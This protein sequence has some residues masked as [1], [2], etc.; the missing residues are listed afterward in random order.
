MPVSQ[1]T[2]AAPWL[3]PTES[4]ALTRFADQVRARYRDRV[5]RAVLFG[6]RARGEGHE[7]SDL[8]VAVILTGADQAVRRALIDLSTDIFL[9]T[10]IKVSPMVLSPDD[11]D[12]LL[13]LRRGVALAIQ[14]EGI[15]C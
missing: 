14:D 2:E 5:K 12:T 11:F 13:R 8:D 9:E 6:S 15:D 10:E 1:P 7:E 3:S 4:A